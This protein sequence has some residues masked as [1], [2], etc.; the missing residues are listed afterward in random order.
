MEVI[1]TRLPE[2]KI[3]QPRVFGDERGHFM[4]AWNR[5]TFEELGL[6]APFVQDN[7]SASSRGVLRG[8]HYQIRAPQGKLV[9][10][11][12]GEVYDVAVDLRAG[13]PHFGQWVAVRLDAHSHRQLWIPPGFAHGFYVLSSRAVFVYKCTD[14]YCPEGERTIRWDDSELA[15]AWP[16]AE[17]GGPVLSEKDAAGVYLRDAECYP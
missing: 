4:E 12:L 17:G 14:Y 11:V 13:S 3:L 15:I 16:L 2:I 9:R 10:V 1:D 8:L 7:E 6:D 5:R